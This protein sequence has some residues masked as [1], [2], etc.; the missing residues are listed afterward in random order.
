MRFLFDSVDEQFNEYLGWFLDDIQ[1]T[2]ILVGSTCTPGLAP[3][4]VP[5]S[6]CTPTIITSSDHG[7]NATVTFDAFNCPSA[8]YHILYGKG[9]NLATWTV[10]DAQCDLGTSGSYAWTG[11]PDLTDYT[12][13]FLWFLVVGDDNSTTEGSWGLTYPGGAEEGGASASGKCSCTTKNT[14]TICGIP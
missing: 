2:N 5:S 1:I 7:T 11:M 6:G 4:R 10:L 8:D 14:S 12:S 3:R 9:E 13:R